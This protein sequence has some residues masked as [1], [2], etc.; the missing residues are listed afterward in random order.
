METITY[1]TVRNNL[2]K[3]MDKVNKD[4]APVIITRQNGKAAVLMS[5]EDFN[6]YEETAYLF[7]S[8][9][10]A[11]RLI[12]AIQDVEKNHIRERKLIEDKD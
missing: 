8:P 12:K 7:R 10:N 3:T 5:L 1:T 9:A 2:S 11:E 4:H 6:A